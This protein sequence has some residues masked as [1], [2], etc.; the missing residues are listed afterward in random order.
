M[1]DDAPQHGKRAQRIKIMSTDVDRLGLIDLDAFV[2]AHGHLY[3]PS[4]FGAVS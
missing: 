4:F 1:E 2:D 3:S